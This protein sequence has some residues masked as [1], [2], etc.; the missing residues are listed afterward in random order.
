[1]I[2]E[3]RNIETNELEGYIYNGMHIPLDPSNR[4]YK[5]VMKLLETEDVVPAYTDEE[6]LE[7]FK[8]K[9]IQELHSEYEKANSKD[10]EYMDTTFQADSKSQDIIAK[11]L[12][13]GSV[14][15]NFYW[16]DKYNNKVPMSYEGLQGLANAIL[17]RNQQNFD[18][19]QLKKELV[20]K[21]ESIE[22]LDTI[23]WE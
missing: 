13:V 3:I 16:L 5:K 6:R 17:A 15:D 21:V 19:L 8:N 12:S 11:V 18:K 14:P 20:R 9:K 2:R 4:H 1:M 23:S 22:E 7:Y 10:V